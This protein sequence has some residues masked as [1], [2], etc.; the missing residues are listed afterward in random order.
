MNQYEWIV[1]QLAK[2]QGGSFIGVPDREGPGR[3]QRPTSHDEAST[4]MVGGLRCLVS[5]PIL[6]S[7]IIPLHCPIVPSYA[8][9][10]PH[11]S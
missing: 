9:R 11:L 2:G 6:K 5:S 1:A 10:I 4:G 3:Q 7:Y 8:P